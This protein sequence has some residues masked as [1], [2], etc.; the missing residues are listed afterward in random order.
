MVTA[1]AAD[2]G[3]LAA[4]NVDVLYTSANNLTDY[5]T[6]IELTQAQVTTLGKNA[7]GQEVLYLFDTREWHVYREGDFAVPEQ[8]FGHFVTFLSSTP[9]D[10]KPLLNPAAPVE[11]WTYDRYGDP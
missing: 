4:Y 5:R 8:Y 7:E 1:R 3:R 2:A 11:R 9:V 6:E 10:L